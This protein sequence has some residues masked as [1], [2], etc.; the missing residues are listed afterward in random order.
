MINYLSKSYK[1]DN[2]GSAIITG[3]V[4]STVLMVLCLSLLLV[5][6]SLFLSESNTS[7]D[8]SNRE[9][10]YSA[11]EVFE[12]ELTLD[13]LDITDLDPSNM[14]NNNIREYIFSSIKS[15]SWPSYNGGD[16]DTCSKYFNIYVPGSTKVVV[17]LFWEKAENSTDENGAILNAIYRAY[18]GK[19]E[20]LVKAEKKYK[21]TI[22]IGS[23]SSDGGT[24]ASGQGVDWGNVELYK[25]IPETN[26]NEQINDDIS[27]GLIVKYMSTGNSSAVLQIINKSS[28]DIN[29]WKIYLFSPEEVVVNDGATCSKVADNIYMLQNLE[30]NGSVT[31]NGGTRSVYLKSPVVYY[32]KAQIVEDVMTPLS[33]ADYNWSFSVKEEWGYSRQSLLVITY[34]GEKTITGWEINFNFGEE[35]T[36]VSESI[37][38]NQIKDPYVIKNNDR[39]FKTLNKNDK[40]TLKVH[41]NGT[42]PSLMPENFVFKTF[43]TNAL[44]SMLGSESKATTWKW[45]RISDI[46]IPIITGG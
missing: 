19:G 23:S 28:E 2:R 41:W 40:I 3:L 42:D 1:S 24:G 20:V 34:L 22:N 45:N 12:H 7:D 17:Q 21:L 46:P 10:V 18:N 43:D 32:P 25:K 15:G 39:D 38:D 14:T 29:S 26:A 37:F 16:I 9:L 27:S 13:P 11:A 35:I 44:D 5:S 6:Y 4:V 33:L 31:A 8:F 30:W 36:Y